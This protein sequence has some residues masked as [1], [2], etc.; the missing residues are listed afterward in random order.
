MIILILV[1]LK[2]ISSDRAKDK[3]SFMPCGR[4]TNI[5]NTYGLSLLTHI[6]SFGV[7]ELDLSVEHATSQVIE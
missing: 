3:S 5:K 7:D 4:H 1:S 2:S 6:W